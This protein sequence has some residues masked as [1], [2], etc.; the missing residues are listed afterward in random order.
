[1]GRGARC[2]PDRIIASIMRSQRRDLV[3]AVLFTN[4]LR[5]MKSLLFHA[6]QAGHVRIDNPSTK[7]LAQCVIDIRWIPENILRAAGTRGAVTH[8]R[9]TVLR[10]VAE[11]RR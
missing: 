4:R 7:L 11:R 9:D 6:I 1:M 8:A 5:Q 10:G 3:H 2:G